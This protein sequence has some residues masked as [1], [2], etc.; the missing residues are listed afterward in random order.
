MAQKSVSIPEFLSMAVLSMSLL[1][2]MAVIA[3]AIVQLRLKHSL[4]LQIVLVVATFDLFGPMLGTVQECFSHSAGYNV[5]TDHA[6]CQ[7]FGAFHSVIPSVSATLVALLALERSLRI[8]GRPL[9]PS[10]YFYIGLAVFITSS[11]LAFLTAYTGG[12][13]MTASRIVCSMSPRNSALSTFHYYIFM[14]MLVVNAIII[15]CSYASII[16]LRFTTAL[17]LCSSGSLPP[18]SSNAFVLRAAIVILSYL[19]LILP[20]FSLM[21]REAISGQ[22]LPYLESCFLAILL[23]SLSLMNPFLLLLFHTSISKTLSWFLWRQFQPPRH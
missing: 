10:T 18:R 21:A 7:V 2:N 13:S 5:L 11:L 15:S 20:C 8:Y 16:R 6:I 12:Y 1:A 17:Q 14:M 22:D 3:A 9:R 23:I 4:G 19:C